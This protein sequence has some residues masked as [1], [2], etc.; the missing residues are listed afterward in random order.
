MGHKALACG[1]LET[2]PE[3][4]EAKECVM[5]KI[6]V[7]AGTA[8]VLANGT[9]VA[10]V[11][12]D[13]NGGG[14]Y[15]G[16]GVGEF[17]TEIDELDDVDD[18]GIDFEE[19][20]DATRVFA[21]YRFNPFLAAQ[22]DYYD[23]GESDTALGLLPVRSDATGI[24]PSIVGTLPLGP[25][26]LFARAGIVFYDLEVNLDNDNVLDETGNDPV[27]SV[28][29]GITLAEHLNLKAEY[30]AVDIDHF[31]EAEGVWLTANWRF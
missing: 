23:F 31:D 5:Y 16:A 20:E 9:A 17:S 19:D 29:I 1:L 18:V 8:L 7:I 2:P 6:C 24:A 22:A 4:D 26:E 30:E 27:Y 25:V 11:D 14:W 21:G 3:A 12:A 15:L 13:D 28:G 10:Q